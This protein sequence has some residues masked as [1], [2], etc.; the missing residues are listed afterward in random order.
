MADSESEDDGS[1]MSEENDADNFGTVSTDL[2][3]YQQDCV[4]NYIKRQLQWNEVRFRVD[5]KEYV[6]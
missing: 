1:I 2:Q 6:W 5:F 3:P 4:K